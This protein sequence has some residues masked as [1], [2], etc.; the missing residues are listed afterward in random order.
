M[1][2]KRRWR[3]EREEQR[4]RRR[5]IDRRLAIFSLFSS[6]VL[7]F[8]VGNTHRFCGSSRR[9]SHLCCASRER[10]KG[11]LFL[12]QADLFLFYFL[13]RA[14]E[15]AKAPPLVARRGDASRL[16]GARTRGSLFRATFS[17]AA[18]D[19]GHEFVAV[20]EGISL[21]ERG[22]TGADERV[23]FFFSQANCRCCKVRQ[24]FFSAEDFERAG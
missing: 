17:A 4:R 24:F 22:R 21:L 11:S 1:G 2:K 13:R 7:L 10:K 9:R 6:S 23:V 16:P 5:P 20:L 15:R 8:F 18:R 19:F 12:K 3:K 14:R